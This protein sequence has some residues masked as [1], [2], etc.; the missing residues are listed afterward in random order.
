MGWTRIRQDIKSATLREEAKKEK[1]SR[2]CRRL[3]GI[4]HLLDGGSRQEAQKI[5]CLTVNTFRTWMKRF[6]EQGIPGL[7]SKQSPGRPVIISQTIAEKLKEKVLAGPSQEEGLVR[8]RISDLQQYLKEEHQITIG[9]SG[10]WY[11]LRALNLSW[12]TG[13][14]RHPKRDDAAQETFKKTSEKSL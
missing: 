6:N 4:A 2:I 7:R 14:Q 12:K 9:I 5:A 1:D 3:L 13:R 8:Y 11:H 10:L